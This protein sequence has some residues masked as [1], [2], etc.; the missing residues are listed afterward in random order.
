MSVKSLRGRFIRR[1]VGVGVVAVAVGSLATACAGDEAQSKS[2]IHLKIGYQT[3]EFPE[4]LK[5]SGLFDDTTYSFE[6]PVI[7]G[8]ANQLAALYGKQI[9]VGL[10]GDNTGAFEAAN[11]AT[12]WTKES[13][14]IQG[15][16]VAWTPQAP[17]P[18]PA[19]YVTKSSGIRSLADL[20]GKKIGYNYG[21]NIYAGYVVA[22]ANGGFG[23]GDVHGVQFP[24]NQAAA[25]SFVAGD[26]DAVVASYPLIK[27]K[28]DAGDAVRIADPKTLGIIGG[29][30]WLA[31]SDVLADPAKQAAIKDF[32]GR[33]RKYYEEWVPTHRDAYVKVLQ[34]VL[35]QTEE[36]AAANY[37][38]AQYTKFY[39]LSDPNFIKIQQSIVT[40]AHRVGG[41]KSNADAALGYTTI[42]DPI[43]TG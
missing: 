22:L 1:L 35:T 9:D 8:P 2:G 18:A 41:L 12:P 27:K 38:N 13:A 20:R 30:G 23:P 26:L 39:R 29:S 34:R 7:N 14:P 40:A 11:A 21:G 43:T 28:L 24:A 31:R 25:S 6:V 15:I 5:E 37:D 16:A 42:L 10:A 4:L 19:V 3:A 32:F 36:V 17:N 33:L